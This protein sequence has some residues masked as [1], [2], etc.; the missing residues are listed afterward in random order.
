M[1]SINSIA[2]KSGLLTKIQV[3]ETVLILSLSVLIPFL[4]HFL[5][6]FNGVAIGAIFLPMFWA[7]YIAVKYFKFH[8]GLIA[9]LTAP[10]LNYWITG[11]PH[12]AII[13]LMTIQLALFVVVSGLLKNFGKLKYLNAVLAY[14]IAIA[15]AS[16]VIISLPALMPNL[17]LG[18]YFMT[19]F[20]SGLPGLILLA[21]INF[22]S[23]RFNNK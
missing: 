2:V 11:N 12:M 5:P 16:I 17:V 13:S 4:V 14:I 8:V 20:V 7:P 6:D 9:A 10:I 21:A 22:A 19:A 3:K 1:E 15:A 18:N 23:V